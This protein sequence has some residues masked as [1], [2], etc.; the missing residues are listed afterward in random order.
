MNSFV[1]GDRQ[2][3]S[4]KLMELTI[5]A[6][7]TFCEISSKLITQRIFEVLDWW[8]AHKLVFPRAVAWFIFSIPASSA[9]CFL[10]LEGSSLLDQMH[11]L[12]TV[13]E[14]QFWYRRKRNRTRTRQLNGDIFS[15][16]S[17]IFFV[18][19]IDKNKWF[20]SCWYIH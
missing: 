11:G 3:T 2:L 18:K 8:Q 7:S 6:F 16:L 5:G 20:C 19:I 15:M 12:S 17:F 13:S 4:R 10:K 9:D 1:P 14:Q